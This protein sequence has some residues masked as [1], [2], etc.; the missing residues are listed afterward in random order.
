M[1]VKT[2]LVPSDFSEY[3][4]HA[5]SYA[6]EMA[7]KWGAKVVVLNAAPMFS[8]LAYPESVYMVDLAKMEAELIADAEKKLREFIAQK[9]TSPVPVETR[10]VL[11]DPFWEICKAAESEHA[12]LIIMGSH[13]RTGLAHVLLG[14]VAERVVRHAPC[15]VLVARVPG[16]EKK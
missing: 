15:P 6:L 13:G 11:G 3:A 4:K 1:Q 10:A 8:H 16:P 12:D 14:S 2:I 9:G 7:D 5:F